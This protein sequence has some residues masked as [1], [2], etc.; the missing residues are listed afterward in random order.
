MVASPT[1]RAFA[2]LLLGLQ[3][4]KNKRMYFLFVISRFC[5]AV[6]DPF[7]FTGIYRTCRIIFLFYLVYE[8]GLIYVLFVN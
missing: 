8:L 3:K 2:F 5:Q 7:T 4:N 1:Q 6:R